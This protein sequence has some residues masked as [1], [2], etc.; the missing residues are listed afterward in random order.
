MLITARCV[1]FIV[2]KK[3]IVYLRNCIEI[4][5]YELLYLHYRLPCRLWLAEPIILLYDV[6][7]LCT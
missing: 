7:E 5:V 3:S 2:K 6:E 1:V 4:L